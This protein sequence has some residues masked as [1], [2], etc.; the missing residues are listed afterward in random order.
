MKSILQKAGVDVPENTKEAWD[1]LDNLSKDLPVEDRIIGRIAYL[2][3]NA[4]LNK[5]QNLLCDSPD[6][7]KSD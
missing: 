3:T 2:I 7:K 4:V 1:A 5:K 6:P